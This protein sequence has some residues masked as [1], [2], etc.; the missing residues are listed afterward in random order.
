MARINIELDIYSG[1]ENPSFVV[2]DDFAH[3]LLTNT[4]SRASDPRGERLGFRGVALSS[5]TDEGAGRLG[6]DELYLSGE[7][8][9]L[10]AN[11]ELLSAIFE[12]FPKDDPDFDQDLLLYLN[13]K[14]ATGTSQTTTILTTGED[15][16]PE[17]AESDAA[18]PSCPIEVETFNPRFWNGSSVVRENNCYNYATNRRTNTFAQPGRATGT[19]PWPV[20]C[21]SVRAAAIS[22][23]AKYGSSPSGFRSCQPDSEIPRWYMV[24]VIWPG[25][26]YHWY[27]KQKEG[28]WGHKLGKE[29]ARNTDNSGKVIYDPETCD[30]GPY[31]EFCNYFISGKSSKVR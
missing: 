16:G 25:Y 12:Q 29:P 1:R 18:L 8:N 22:D 24:M 13:N 27:R 23:G 7:G 2:E 15:D 21:D 28:Y 19:Y 17:A 4:A 20:D 5:L 14:L 11:S 9:A 6:D 31:T 3:W 26:D 10:A 30:R